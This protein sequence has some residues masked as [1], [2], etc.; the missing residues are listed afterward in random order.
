M[1]LRILLF[2]SVATMLV[3]PQYAFSE[4]SSGDSDTVSFDK[5]N[6]T[7]VPVL[8]QETLDT[9]VSNATNSSDSSSQN[10][11]SDD[12]NDSS[13]G[14]N[15]TSND[16]SPSNSGITND[17]SLNT[18]TNSTNLNTGTSSTNLN[19]GTNSTN[20]NT[21]VT[22]NTKTN[23]TM[24]D[25]T[26][27]SVTPSTATVSKGS[28]IQFTVRTY[29]TTNSQTIPSGIV[30]W[31]DG[32]TGG[33]FSPTSCT[34]SSGKCL[35]MYTPN[36]N[37][38]GNII[39]AANYGGDSTHSAS[40]GT[41][42]VTSNVPSDVTLVITSSANNISPGSKV[43]LTV[44]LTDTSNLPT[45]PTGMISWSDNNSGGVFSA[46]SCILS[47]GS[48]IVSYTS[49]QDHGGNMAISA[50]YAG[51]TL[52]NAKSDAGIFTLAVNLLP[53]TTTAVTPSAVTINQGSQ[54]QFTASITD[55]SSLPTIPSGV[56]TWTD[57]NAGGTF[58]PDS[59]DL[60]S[61]KCS[62][63]YTPSSTTPSSVTITAAYGG[64][65]EHSGSTGTSVLTIN[66]LHTT[67]T[68]VTPNSVTVAQGSQVQLTATTTDVSKSQTAATGDVTWTDGNAGGTFNP[69]TC[70]L[71]SD[72]CTVTYTPSAYSTNTVTINATYGGDST[73]S[74]S[75]GTSSA[76]IIV[77]PSSI[78]LN[79]DQSYYA[80]GDVVT[81]SANLPGQSLQ[82]IAVGVSNPTGDNII[83]RTI[84][85][86]ENGTASL[87][88]KIPDTYQTGV[89]HDIVT[90]L[91]DGR[92]YTNSTEFNVIKS[93][94]VTIDSVQ[95]TNQQ[96]DPVSILP[97][98]QN[99]FVK[100]SIS[101]GEKMPALL[102]LNLFD[103]GQSSLGTT[104]I[105]STVNP[106]TSQMTLSFFIPANVQVGLAN[107]FTD[108][109]SDWPNN[110]GTPLTAE[111]CLAADLQDTSLL[112]ASYVP[113]APHACTNTSGGVLG[114][115]NTVSTAMTNS[116]AQVTLGVLIQNDSMTFM[117]PTQA[118]LLAL[119]Y[120]NN[121][122]QK[123]GNSVGTV[124][125]DVNS[126]NGTS[127]NISPTQF[128]TLAGPDLQNNPMAMKILQE[129][130]VS[131]RQVANIIGNETAA[132]LDQQLILQQ[133]QAAASQ[134]KQDLTVLAEANTSTSSDAAY[135]SFL[136]TVD[137][138]RTHPVFQDEFN[139]MKQRVTVANTAM[140]SVLNNGGSLGQALATFNKY[141]TI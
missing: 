59:C 24:L 83:S 103:A 25:S 55:T 43:Q 108:V 130:E 66:I 7:V 33:T 30:T 104:S 82:S 20:L 96:G 50:T 136:T 118:H 93:R 27:S 80:Y 126:L 79:T 29:D 117:S 128:T 110:G 77:L 22:N 49:P 3:F 8:S 100:V 14:T 34:L 109:Y 35:V 37:Y 101:S 71:S 89:Y 129:I 124:N 39:V 16:Q 133:R 28:Q 11:I 121:T 122:G 10:A 44:S 141:A 92:N 5:S 9:G 84:T 134:L 140:Q 98:G 135:A 52:H 45:V 18:G 88:F 111:S 131:K 56:V 69:T 41:S 112:P 85:T 17:T 113:D 70:Y 138:N 74:A 26:S 13:S 123:E 53:S 94:G 86:N 54:V 97:K 132:K 32:N 139:F 36:T 105:K 125:V 48:C 114:T 116:Q 62:V 38:R 81:L 73:H 76:S 47:S 15:S 21:G 51:D 137:D 57:G 60:L 107:V 91:V 40:A 42:T 78:S 4:S 87:Q 115:G 64:S 119:A 1:D 95:I 127:A 23:I 6:S 90:A 12:A 67:V 46:T 120:Q 65:T 99:G 58:N 61:G 2:V 72:A 102:T 31:T 75:V 106:G 63:L 68:S 19:A